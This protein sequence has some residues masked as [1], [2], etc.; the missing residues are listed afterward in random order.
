MAIK[1][2]YLYS[3]TGHGRFPI[4]MLRYDQAWPEHE[5]D[6]GLIE[7]IGSPRSGMVAA[8]IDLVALTNPTVGRWQSF[9]W[10]V[11]P[12]TLRAWRV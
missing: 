2:R 1:V 6:A 3:V 9:G 5:T 7:Q 8:T 10:D 12:G 4:D 11:A